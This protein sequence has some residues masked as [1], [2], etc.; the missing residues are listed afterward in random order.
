MTLIAATNGDPSALAG[1][2]QAAVQSID[3]NMPVFRV[4]TMEDIFEH[5][6]VGLLR[7]VSQIYD[8]AAGMGL[9]M[10]LVGL[11]A[12]VSYQVARRT[13]EIGIRMALGAKRA[14]VV[15]IFLNHALGM[16]LAGISI[17]LIVSVFANQLS[18]SALG[19]GTLDPWLS[20][21]VSAALLLTSLAAAMIPARRAARIDPQQALRQD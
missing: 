18:Q 20:A 8:L 7:A 19:I 15:R 13:R 2:L 3:P 6:S 10:A 5:S 9:L 17:G 1:P 16:S 4:R 21:S 11:Y 14:Q 12:V